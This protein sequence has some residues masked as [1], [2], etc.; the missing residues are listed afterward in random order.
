MQW[1]KPLEVVFLT[2]FSDACFRAIPWVAQLADDLSIGLTIAH[3]Y[4]PQ[5]ARRAEVEALLSSFFPEADHFARTSRVAMPG[6]PVNLL[7]KLEETRDV[8]LVICPASDALGM[9]RLGHRSLRASILHDC[10]FPVWTIGRHTDTVKLKQP[11]KNVACWVEAGHQAPVHL[12]LAVAYATA[13]EAQ[14]HVLHLVPEI[15]EGLMALPTIED[16]PLHEDGAR[17]A[18]EDLVPRSTQSL[19]VHVASGNGVR[20]QSKLLKQ[21]NADVAFASVERFALTDWIRSDIDRVDRHACPTICVSS[22]AAS[23]EWN[24]LPGPAYATRQSERGNLVT[25][26]PASFYSQKAS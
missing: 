11:V 21:C 20:S 24:L 5:V 23:R 17:R 7:R 13:L 2:N 18:V 9:P 1:R 22:R 8:D 10:G 3:A 12:K 25:S 14:L 26:I 19:H 6:D 4:D 15:H 16:R